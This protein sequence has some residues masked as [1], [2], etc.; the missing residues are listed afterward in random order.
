MRLLLEHEAQVDAQDEHQGNASALMLALENG[1]PQIAEM[2][3]EAGADLT[4]KD[5]AGWTPLRD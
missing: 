3:I 2:L 5:D 1:Q 4:L